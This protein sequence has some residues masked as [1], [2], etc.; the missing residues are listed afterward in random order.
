MNE[1]LGASF[2]EMMTVCE[3]AAARDDGKFAFTGGSWPGGSVGAGGRAATLDSLADAR[4]RSQ[5][6]ETPTIAYVGPEGF[7]I[8]GLEF[9][10]SPFADPQGDGT[11]GAM[12]WRLAEVSAI[13]DPDS[14]PLSDPVWK[15]RPVALEIDTVW[16]SELIF[17]EQ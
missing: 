14:V 4:D 15:E 2:S 16:Q 3:V 11:L 10:S 12:R 9:D 8:D 13:P 5:L 6:P 17:A 7:P 1:T